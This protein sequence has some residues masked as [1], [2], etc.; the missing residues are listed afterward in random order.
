MLVS[1]EWLKKYVKFDITPEE[2]ADKLTRVGLEV[3]EVKHQGE[4]ISGVV[5]GKVMSI[6]RN[7]KSD[8]LW[9]CQLD[10]GTGELVQ[11]QT[12]AQNVK[13]HD[14][15]PVATVG[16][17]LPNGMKLKPVK[18]AGLDSYGM[19]CSAG[20]LGI[21]SKLLLPEQREGILIL[22]P[23][24]P[25]GKDIRQVLGL[26]D[27]VLDI[28]LTANKQDCF[29]MTGIAREAAAVLGEKMSLPD[30]SVKEN[31]GRRIED[32]MK[33]EIQVPELC[34]RFANR[35]IT[36]IKIMPSPA[37]M[38]NELRA[39]GIRPISNVVDVTNYVMMELGQPMHAYD[40]DTLKDHTLI[41]RQ[42]H[43]GEKLTTLDGKVRDLTP[44]MVVIA[45]TEKA[46]GLGGVMGGLQTEV[47]DK[48]HTVILEAATFNGPSIRHTSKALGLRSEASMRFERGVD[49][50]HTWYALDRAVHLLEEMGACKSVQGICESYP[51]P[52]VP[53]VL[54]ISPDAMN[55]R[56]GV[57]ISVEE[58]TDILQKLEFGVELQADG[59]LKVTVPSW[60]S[61]VTCDADISEEIARM[62]SYD[63][64]GSHYPLLAM[65][66]GKED[67]MERGKDEVQDY[68]AS[69]GL[70]EVQNY[71]FI[72]PS[73][74]DKLL[75]PDGDSRRRTIRILNPISEEFSTMRTTMLPGLLA[76]AAYNLARQAESVKIFETGR[77][78]LPK[79][80][81]LTEHPEEQQRVGAVMTGR[82]EELN[83]TSGKES[84]DFYDMKGVVEGL[85][86]KMHLTG[87]T[88]APADEPYLHPG[89][90]CSIQW[91]GRTIGTFGCLHPTVAANWNVGEETYV[92][93]MELQPLVEA[94]AVVPQYT[95]LAKFPGTSRDIAV[96]V[97]VS[98]SMEEL[99]QVIRAH[100][101]E[102]L[103]DVRVF[104]VYT[105]KQVGEGNKSVAFNL[106]FRA[107]D[108]TLKDAEI[109]SIMKTVVENVQNTYQAE[110]RK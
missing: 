43:A 23:D 39:V 74:A 24:T 89:K 12:G 107:E 60:R 72:H 42:A 17:T 67:P 52:F 34:S 61:D 73:F 46:V 1:I 49:T 37:W 77:V 63:K 104:D 6:E 70:D 26:N 48:T 53:T 16:A 15:V 110:L 88:L 69:A 9:V 82:R 106:T 13:L 8:H 65:R 103:Q 20:E 29:C 64:I 94:A 44:D 38:Q 71:T 99:E 78:Y 10:Y 84:V 22:A 101:G 62:H 28:D 11:I 92:L 96:V 5:T 14:M 109:D 27:T 55:T 4:G 2:L 97:P 31:D 18:M 50:E 19:L 66:Q 21:D 36:D 79:A 54:M 57:K 87:Y 80:L 40:Y 83:W 81:P 93:E 7:P 3:E 86:E 75:L 76:T 85:F 102:L 56:I 100:A 98:V 95:K 91:K 68:L 41:V 47:T 58:M 51:V 59:N 45:D 105:G 33:N 30:M 32:M 25:I 90:S 35:I 108:R